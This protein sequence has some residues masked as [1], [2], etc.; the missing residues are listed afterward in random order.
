MADVYNR[1]VFVTGTEVMRP[2]TYLWASPEDQVGLLGSN[3]RVKCIFAGKYV[4]SA[5]GREAVFIAVR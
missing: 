5:E 4:H 1:F 2:A 3:F